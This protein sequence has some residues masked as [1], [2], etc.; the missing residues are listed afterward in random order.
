MQVKLLRVLQEREIQRVGDSRKI[1]IDIRI[2]AA[3]H[4][5]LYRR[6]QEGKFREDLYYRL[7]VFPIHIPPLRSRREDIPLLVRAIHR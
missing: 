3:T 4:K 5:D 1:K 7:K 6:T 2:L